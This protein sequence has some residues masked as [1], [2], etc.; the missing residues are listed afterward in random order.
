MAMPTW[1]IQG[2]KILARQSEH[3]KAALAADGLAGTAPTFAEMQNPKPLPAW[4]I[5]DHLGLAPIRYRV[6]RTLLKPSG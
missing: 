4:Q 3:G 5:P 6:L 1:W 2:P